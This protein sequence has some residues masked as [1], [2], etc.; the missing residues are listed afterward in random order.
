MDP[1]VKGKMEENLARYQNAW[2]LRKK[3]VLNSV[4]TIAEGMEKKSSDIFE[5]VGLE[6]E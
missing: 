1:E 5:L 2:K 6:T 3:I 4:G